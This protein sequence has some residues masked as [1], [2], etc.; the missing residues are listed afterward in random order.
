MSRTYSIQRQIKYLASRVCKGTTQEGY[1]LSLKTLKTP[2]SKETNIKNWSS[3][4]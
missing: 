3:G 4:N 1:I 2:C